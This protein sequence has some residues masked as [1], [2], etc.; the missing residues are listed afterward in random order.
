MAIRPDRAYEVRPLASAFTAV[1][2][3]AVLIDMI[4]GSIRSGESRHLI[5][6]GGLAILWLL[7]TEMGPGRARSGPLGRPLLSGF[8]R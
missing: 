2:I 8:R 4:S 3:L 5:E 7:G 6:I 1:L